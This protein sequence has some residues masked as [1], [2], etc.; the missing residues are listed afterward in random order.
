MVGVRCSATPARLAP[1]CPRRGLDPGGCSHPC[2]L[3]HERVLEGQRLGG[4]SGAVGSEIL[5]SSSDHGRHDGHGVES[6]LGAPSHGAE[7][8]VSPFVLLPDRSALLG[9]QS[10]VQN[11]RIAGS[12]IAPLYHL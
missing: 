7:R 10:R 3:I 11:T 4:G 2:P 6:P 1:T 8:L 5:T 9:L 12:D